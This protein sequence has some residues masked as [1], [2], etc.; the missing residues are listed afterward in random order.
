[1]ELGRART[2]S[3]DEARDGRGRDARNWP[4]RI[5][6]L[7]LRQAERAK[8]AAAPETLTFAKAAQAYLEARGE[9]DKQ[10]T[11]RRIP[12]HAEKIRV[13]ADWRGRCRRNRHSAR[14]AVLEQKV[15]AIKGYP[16]GLFWR[17]GRSRPAGSEIAWSWC[18]IWSSVRGYRHRGRQIRTELGTSFNT[19]CRRRD[20]LPGVCTTGPCPYVEVPVLV[21][22]LRQREGVAAKASVFAELGI[23]RAGETL[24]ATERNRIR[25]RESGVDHPRRA[26]EIAA[27]TPRAISP[28]SDRAA[29]MHP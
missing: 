8:A 7:A 19:C 10:E 5:D 6:P 28:G 11:S 26:D 4:T 23:G 20:R 25:Y 22:A 15:P 16:A 14:V 12:V 29:A 9:V 1:M 3:L 24:G 18:S 21:A 27:S 2:F 17:R 13:P